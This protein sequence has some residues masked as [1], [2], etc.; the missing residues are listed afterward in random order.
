MTTRI[1]INGV[2][3]EETNAR[4]SVLDRGVLYGD[5][6]YE[7]LRTYGGRPWALDE[8][9]ERL[10]RS[11]A[12]LGFG[13]PPPPERLAAE[14]E[15]VLGASGNPQAGR[16]SYLRLIIT[17]GAGPIGLA[18][19]LASEPARVV[20][21]TELHLLPAAFYEQGVAVRL[22][23]AAA[24]S[25]IAICGGAKSGNY[26]PNILALG[27]AQAH[28]AHEALLLDAA[29]RVAEGSSSNIFAVLDDVLHTPALDVGILEGITR[30]KVIALARANGHVVREGELRPADLRRASEIFLTSTL[31]EVL[32]VTQVDDWVVGTGR[33]GAVARQLRAAYHRSI[34]G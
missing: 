6:I 23:S 4:I 5:S 28:G 22:V 11:A 1:A 31:R 15:A 18:P 25:A 30:H 26:L 17:R 13:C 33:P 27:E 8:H 29:G 32:P 3:S 12:L 16:E 34:E 21:V 19:Q 20:I 24:G 7:V 14:I 9:L 2:I 10:H